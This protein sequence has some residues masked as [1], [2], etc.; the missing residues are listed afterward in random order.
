MSSSQPL[1]PTRHRK[2]VSGIFI[3]S[4]SQE[5]Y[6]Y[7]RTT[8]VCLVFITSFIFVVVFAPSVQVLFV[9]EVCF[10]SHCF[11]GAV[12]YSAIDAVWL[13]LGSVLGGM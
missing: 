13:P 2:R 10:V 8:Q 9:G 5:R 4:W 12:T 1:F 7:R 11:F 6:G 3:S